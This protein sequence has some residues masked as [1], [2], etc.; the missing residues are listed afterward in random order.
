MIRTANCGT[1]E[2]SS[3]GSLR[4]YH[5]RE[6][7]HDG[8]VDTEFGGVVNARVLVWGLRRQEAG[9]CCRGE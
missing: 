8:K 9:V 1:T 3:L 6:V 5:L 2:E 7:F 4:N